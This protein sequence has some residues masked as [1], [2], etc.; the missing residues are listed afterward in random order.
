MC[1]EKAD[2]FDY[3]PPV[4]YNCPAGRKEAPDPKA[5]E[6]FS[7]ENI[8]IFSACVAGIIILLCITC[9][10]VSRWLCPK[11]TLVY[12]KDKIEVEEYKPKSTKIRV[13]KKTKEMKYANK[14]KKWQQKLFKEQ[15]LT[16]KR[17]QVLPTTES[18]DNLKRVDSHP[19]IGVVFP[20]IDNQTPTPIL[21]H[22]Q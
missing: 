6:I 16:S 12:N 5:Q 7:T 4:T 19:N 21:K 14:V 15:E 11:P 1:G 17:S 8:A 2:L 10:L 22:K 20:E 9:C 3:P 13:N 18:L